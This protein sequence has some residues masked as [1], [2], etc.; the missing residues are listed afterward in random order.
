M[1]NN[2]RPMSALSPHPFRIAPSILSAD[3]ARLGDEVKA[4]LAAGADLIHFDVMDNHYVPNL[5]FGPVVCEALDA[6]VPRDG[7]F[8]VL[9]VGCGSGGYLRHAAARNPALTALGLEVGPGL[10]A[11]ARRNVAAW[12]LA[13]RVTVEEGDVVERLLEERLGHHAGLSTVPAEH[14]DA[15][16]VVLHR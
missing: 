13:D 12:G 3:L 4:V 1:W 14:D 2:A 15:G 10:L 7:P 8:R 5:T 6:E 11:L 9:D 16:I